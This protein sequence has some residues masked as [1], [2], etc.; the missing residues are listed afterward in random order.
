MG[1]LV[2]GKKDGVGAVMTDVCVGTAASSVLGCDGTAAEVATSPPADATP[3][4]VA[5]GVWFLKKLP[6]SAGEVSA[7]VMALAGRPPVRAGF[8]PDW[9]LSNV[10]KSAARAGSV[11]AAGVSELRRMTVGVYAARDVVLNVGMT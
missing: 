1:M 8:G 6:E 11:L 9:F 3:D 2:P 5:A 10:R 7:V 4:L